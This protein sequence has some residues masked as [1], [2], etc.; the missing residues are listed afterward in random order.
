M[1]NHLQEPMRVTLAK[2]SLFVN[3]T[4]VD[5]ILRNPSAFRHEGVRIL[6]ITFGL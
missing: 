5:N 1:E 3:F 6:Q 2:N 4:G